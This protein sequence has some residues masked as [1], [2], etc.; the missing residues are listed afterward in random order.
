[1]SIV[2]IPPDRNMAQTYRQILSAVPDKITFSFNTSKQSPSETLKNGL[3][4]AVYAT[5]RLYYLSIPQGPKERQTRK[6]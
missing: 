2:F 6:K 3:L 4:V 1:M 5:M